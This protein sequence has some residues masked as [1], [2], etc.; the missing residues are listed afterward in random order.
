[1]QHRLRDQRCFQIVLEICQP[2]GRQIQ[3][4]D[5][6]SIAEI[7]ATN[8]VENLA[9]SFEWN[10]MRGVQVHTQSMHSRTVLH[11]TWNEFRKICSL[12][13]LTIRTGFRVRMILGDVQ[14]NLG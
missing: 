9:G 10:E 14:S 6:G 12:G 7:R 5:D 2:F 13:L 3:V 1:M 11:I 8:R 4:Q